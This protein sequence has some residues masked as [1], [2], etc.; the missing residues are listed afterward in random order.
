[1]DGTFVRFADSADLPLSYGAS[2]TVLPTGQVLVLDGDI[3]APRI[4]VFTAQLERIGV[5]ESAAGEPFQSPRSISAGPDG[6]VYLVDR[7]PDYPERTRL[8]RFFVTGLG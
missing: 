4:H 8:R 6:A 5:I 3:D 1:V 7:R 2:I